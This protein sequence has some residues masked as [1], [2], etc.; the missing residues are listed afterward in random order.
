V[1]AIVEAASSGAGSDAADRPAR[2]L[3][4]SVGGDRG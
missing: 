4:T 1:E 2:S 3:T